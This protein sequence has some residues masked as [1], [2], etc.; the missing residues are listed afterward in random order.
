MLSSEQEQSCYSCFFVTCISAVAM[1]KEKEGGREIDSESWMTRREKITT[2][3]IVLRGTRG[4]TGETITTIVE[5]D[6]TI[7]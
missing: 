1:R 5:E 6:E 3:T 2:G 4:G 7:N